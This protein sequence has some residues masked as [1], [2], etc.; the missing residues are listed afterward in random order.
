MNN[1]KKS[2]DGIK[3][4]MANSGVKKGKSKIDRI[5]V[6]GE[7]ITD[8][9]IIAKAFNN[10]FSNIAKTLDN[11]IPELDSDENDNL[12]M[13]NHSFYMFPNPGIQK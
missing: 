13:H 1:V 3:S 9:L 4:L 11:D 2:W 8:E 12:I 10:Y 5:S 7:L 6:N